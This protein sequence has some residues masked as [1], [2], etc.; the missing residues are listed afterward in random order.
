[1]TDKEKTKAQLLAEN[2]QLAKELLTL[3]TKL[4]VEDQY[5]SFLQDFQGI[6]YRLDMRWNPIFFHG[7]VN[8]LTGYSETDLLNRKPDWYD[9]VYPDDL[10]E[11]QTKYHGR[12]FRKPEFKAQREYRILTRTGEIRW[13]HDT[14]QT[15]SDING[16]PMYIQGAVFDITER[17]LAEEHIRRSEAKYRELS[18]QLGETNSIKDL[19]LDVITH[20][21]RNA[22]GNIFGF[23]SLLKEMNPTL[24]FIDNIETSSLSLLSVIDNASTLAKISAGEK[25]D[26]VKLN[27][28]E[29]IKDSLEEFTP[30]NGKA[31]VEIKL[32]LH[33]KL[34]VNANPIISEVFKNYVSNAI[35]YAHEGHLVIVE[36]LK[37]GEYIKVMVKDFGNTI[38]E[39]S[40]KIIFERRITLDKTRKLNS[41][42]GLAIVKKIADIHDAEAWV[43]PNHPTGNIFCLR[44][45]EIG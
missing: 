23:A 44:I 11:L 25:I 1:M 43:E 27:L 42:L 6:A 38:P 22:A 4:P 16:T 15:I 21:L 17:K 20:D 19:L 39:D 30:M 3:K 35:K 41:G 37:E 8:Q 40:R 45:R 10:P 32:R 5:R 34:M 24:E 13:I 36:T 9:I 28:T 26:M 18:E 7:A 33:E 31:L 2:R 12:E 14:I 29:I